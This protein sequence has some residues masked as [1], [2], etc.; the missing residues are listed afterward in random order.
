MMFR[1][2]SKARTVSPAPKA[3]ASPAWDAVRRCV[4]LVV[5]SLLAVSIIA[6]SVLPASAQRRVMPVRDAEIEAL[7]R[8]YARPIFKAAGLGGGEI[9][10]VLVDDK[11]FNAFVADSHRVFINVGAIQQTDTPNQLIG[12]IAHEAAHMAGGHLLR[13]REAVARARTMAVIAMLVGAGA[14]AAGVATGGNSGGQIAQGGQAIMLGG[15]SVAERSVLAYAR[16]EET[17]A[18]RAA[19]N[20]LAATGQSARGMI[21]V[22]RKFADQNMFASRFIDPYAQTHPMPVERIAQI[23]NVARASKFFDTADSAALRERHDLAKAKLS[24]FLEHPGTV[25]RRYPKSDT[26]LPARYARAIAAYRSGDM[27][28]G[29]KQIDALIKE[30]PNNPWFHELKGQ[31]LFENGKPREAIE[32]YRRATALAPD[33]GLI[34]V[35][36]GISLAETNDD[37]YLDEAIRE[38]SA[39]LRADEDVPV[40]FRYLGQAYARKGDTGMAE[41]A[42]AQ[43]YFAL[44]DF[45][46]AQ[47]M[48]RRARAKLKKGSPGW[49]RANDI[50]TYN[51]PKL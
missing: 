44:G 23:E 31:A 11:S 35:Y 38:L 28:S 5:S 48:A 19:L 16:G 9:G 24:G 41:L 10:V 14:M 39:G 45:K 42:S 43:Q 36:L 8:D 1:L 4:R 3:Q 29:L 27:K 47:D 46:G 34:R 26:S 6:S 37:R 50:V 15:Q 30:R 25:A 32:P 49:L 12:V 2:G 33:S 13:L 40:G 21:E 18:D 20:Y 7:M 51:P 22:F 17:A